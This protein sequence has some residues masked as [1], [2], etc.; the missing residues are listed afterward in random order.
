M[1]PVEIDQDDFDH[2]LD[3]SAASSLNKHVT[4][5]DCCVSVSTL[6][7]CLTRTS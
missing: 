4:F 2:F 5:A 3:D 1:S 6:K 7:A